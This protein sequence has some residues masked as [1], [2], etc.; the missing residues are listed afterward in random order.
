MAFA[1]ISEEG[2]AKGVR[3]I[4][5]V[6]GER[7]SRAMELASSIDTDIIDASKLDGVTLEKK[8]GSIKSTLDAAAIPAT[9]K[10]DLR[11]KVSALEVSKCFSS[12]CV[13]TSSS[14]RKG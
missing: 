7:A 8:I 1:I 5:G 14:Q 10:A 2:V 11:R 13:F 9:K 4:T 6:T 12:T 3:R